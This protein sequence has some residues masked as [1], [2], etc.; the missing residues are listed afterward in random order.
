[1]SLNR[2]VSAVLEIESG[3]NDPM[4]VFMTLA[5][6]EY[7]V[8][9]EHYTWIDTLVLFVRQAGIGA[10]IGWWGG[11]LVVTAINRLEL[12][13]SLYPLLTLFSGLAIFGVT[14]LL[15]GSGFLA[16]YLAGLV[17]GNQRVRAYASIRRFH[18]GIAWMSQIGMF[19]ILGLL[20]TPHSLVTI[21]FPAL[22]ISGVL[23]VVARP[24]SV[25][26]SLLPFRIPWREQ[27]YISWVGLRGS[28]PI[29]ARNVP[30]ARRR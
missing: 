27:I 8:A 2:R 3:S 6:L 5:V 10:V 19:V 4:A 11:R 1:M 15:G 26:M 7:L 21:A 28:V 25:A 20:V 12:A 14:G 24:L 22:L 30:A 23:I 13:E 17:V 18:D 16:V 9:G 29:P